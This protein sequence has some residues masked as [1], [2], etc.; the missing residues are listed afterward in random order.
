MVPVL[1][2]SDLQVYGELF[3]G[4][5][6]TDDQWF[7][8][9]LVT[10]W[11]GERVVDLTIKKNLSQF[12]RTAV[13]G[14]VFESLNVMMPGSRNPLVWLPQPFGIRQFDIHFDSHIVLTVGRF[15]HWSGDGSKFSQIGKAARE[16]AEIQTASADIII[17]AAA[18]HEY[19]GIPLA[20]EFA[21]LD[22]LVD[23]QRSVA[24]GLRGIL[25]EIWGLKP[26]SASTRALLR[27]QRLSEANLTTAKG[28]R[29][30]AELDVQVSVKR[31]ANLKQQ[32]EQAWKKLE[33]T[34]KRASE[35]TK[36]LTNVSH[37]SMIKLRREEA[38]PHLKEDRLKQ[39]EKNG[40]DKEAGAAQEEL[41][42]SRNN[43]LVAKIEKEEMWLIQH[44]RTL[45]NMQR[46]QRDAYEELVAALGHASQ[47]ISSSNHAPG[48]ARQAGNGVEARP[49][50]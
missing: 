15:T 47:Q 4:M 29:K 1:E 20:L 31:I 9:F 42:L 43:K 38:K 24:G 25:P 40:K 39:F 22:I 46:M 8:R 18:A 5:P 12:N 45:Q 13:R 28:V 14:G 7:N 23:M 3:P 19:V 44:I 35:I 32:E 11:R 26:M 37:G 48:G 2:T 6:A 21:H 34:R 50:A 33:E 16:C 10:T 49:A 27:P 30:R 36:L 17:C 41:L